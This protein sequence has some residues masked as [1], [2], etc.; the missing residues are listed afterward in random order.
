MHRL[1]PSL[2]FGGGGGFSPLD[3]D[4]LTL[5]LDGSDITTLYQDNAKTT[6][7]TADGQVVGAMADKSL[8][9]RDVLQAT[10]INKPL[11]KAAI[12]NGLSV[13]RFDGANDYLKASPFTLN[14]PTFLFIVVKV[15]SGVE[16]R[17]YHDG[18][19][20]DQMGG[21]QRVAG[22]NYEQYAGAYGAL[23]TLGTANFRLVSSLYNGAAST[24]ALDNEADQS[25][26]VGAS[27]A[28]GFTLGC[29]GDASGNW[30]NID[31]GEVLIYSSVLSAANQAS[32]KNYLIDKW[33]I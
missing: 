24:V 10:A 32:V 8:N 20:L 11:Y 19:A 15:L 14:Q 6:P 21:M 4:G 22:A 5:W 2:R 31:V 12:Q 28:G 27:N 23:I 18:N 25:G 3:I 16:N 7:V 29:R 33:S 9:G 17:Y 30:S 1:R 13:V 26:D